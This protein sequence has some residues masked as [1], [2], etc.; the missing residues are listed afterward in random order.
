[1][2]TGSNQA[3]SIGFKAIL[4]NILILLW[5]ELALFSTKFKTLN[6]NINKKERKTF[7]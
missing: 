4:E 6:S 1:M 2:R 7:V 5:S 3:E